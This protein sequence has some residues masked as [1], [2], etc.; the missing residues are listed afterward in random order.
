[1]K[2]GVLRQASEGMNAKYS[3]RCASQVFRDNC[4][5][6]GGQLGTCLHSRTATSSLSPT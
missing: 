3:E 1:M 5:G 4:E 6:Q 2:L